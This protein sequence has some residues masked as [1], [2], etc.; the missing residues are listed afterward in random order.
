MR[1]YW[2][3][4]YSHNDGLHPGWVAAFMRQQRMAYRMRRIIRYQQAMS[5]KT[6]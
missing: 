5:T 3:I 4:Q 1:R 2:Q 6:L